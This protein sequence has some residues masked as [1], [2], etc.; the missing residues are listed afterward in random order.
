MSG[1]LSHLFRDREFLRRTGTAVAL[2]A[3][4]AILL[5]ELKN[6]CGFIRLYFL[7]RSKLSR[8]QHSIQRLSSK[9]EKSSNGRAWALVTGASDGI[10]YGFVQQLAS[11]SFNVILHGRNDTKI[12]GLIKTLR[13]EFP[14]TEFESFICDAANR[15]KW[16]PAFD[17]LLAT[18]EQRN[19]NLTILVNNVGGTRAFDCLGDYKYENLNALIDTNAV[20]PT[21]ITRALLPTLISNKPSLIVN[22]SSMGGVLPLPFLS[23]YNGSKAFNRH[24]SKSLRMELMAEGHSEVEV[25]SIIAASVQSAGMTV[26]TS[27]VVPSSKAFAGSVLGLVGCGREEFNGWWAHAI[28]LWFVGT[29]MPTWLRER[30]MIKTMQQTKE[31]LS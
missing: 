2:G 28:Q 26:E 14:D 8:Y 17:G 15:E 25:L 27:M 9:E 20:F 13:K 16:S 3:I 6:L 4:G 30:I 7:H 12:Q 11:K 18:I 1:P 23:G 21:Q 29:L 10:G 31:T 24:L 22:M 19:I 5:P